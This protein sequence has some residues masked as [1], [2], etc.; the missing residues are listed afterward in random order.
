[1]SAIAEY[2]E[3]HLAP[4]TLAVLALRVFLLT[5]VLMH[6]FSAFAGSRDRKAINPTERAIKVRLPIRIT[7]FTQ[8]TI[9]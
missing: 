2:P 8:A 9:R 6:N 4:I 3:G 7:L 5:V 1:V